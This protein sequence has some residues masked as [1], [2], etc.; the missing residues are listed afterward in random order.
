[1]VHVEKTA[2]VV[3]VMGNDD[4]ARGGN[5]FADD[6]RAAGLSRT[7]GDEGGDSRGSL[8]ERAMLGCFLLKTERNKKQKPLNIF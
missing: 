4:F 8:F 3:F 2:A 1:M 6:E 5:V 7:D